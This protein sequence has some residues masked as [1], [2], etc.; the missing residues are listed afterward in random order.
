MHQF[1]TEVAFSSPVPLCAIW[2]IL[3]FVSMRLASRNP[4]LLKKMDSAIDVKLMPLVRPSR[5][6]TLA[7]NQ[8]VDCRSSR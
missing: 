6:P 3:L 2:S 7:M 8:I 5:P 4:M 1:A